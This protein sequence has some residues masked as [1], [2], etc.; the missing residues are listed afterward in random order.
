MAGVRREF[1]SRWAQG[2]GGTDPGDIKTELGWVAEK[3][4]YQYFNWWQS[5]VDDMLAHYEE[6]GVADW[7]T[8][9]AYLIGGLAMGS[10]ALIYRAVQANTGIDP[11]SDGGTNW[12]LYVRTATATNPGVM[13]IATAGETAALADGT[14]AVT[15]GTLA[16]AI[17][18]QAGKGIVRLATT[19]QAQA[20]S[21]VLLAITA[22]TLGDVIATE[23]AKGIV[24][25]ADAAEVLTGTDI[26]KAVSPGALGALASSLAETG[27]Q[28]FPGGLIIQWGRTINVA[29]TAHDVTLPLEFPNNHFAAFASIELAW[30]NQDD[31][32]RSPGAEAFSLAAIRLSAQETIPAVH[33][34]AIGN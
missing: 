6:Q 34:L 17:A 25:L 5:R 29:G 27:F 4:P 10:D 18:T 20:L 8:G 13:R 30:Q 11:T 21:E 7:D 23:S 16:A 28:T 32:K 24:Q 15:P 12:L 3:P 33:W 19:A 2:P 1:S 9:T 31:V 26:T 22:S 14:I